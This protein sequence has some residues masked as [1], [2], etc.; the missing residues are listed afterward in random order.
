MN[1]LHLFPSENAPKSSLD[2]TM[3][4][5]ANKSAPSFAE[6]YALYPRKQAKAAAQKTW[7][8]LT[9]AQRSEALE[10]LP[11]HIA[12]WER[13]GTEKAFIPHPATWLNGARWEDELFAPEQKKVQQAAPVV[14]WWASMSGMRAKAAELGIPAD[15]PSETGPAFK[16]RILKAL[17][18]GDRLMRAG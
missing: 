4:T 15:A 16:S 6:W 9:Q 17:D 1:V 5:A 7:G 12:N 3:P 11:T 10:A 13:H 2:R 18:D 14:Q 8:K